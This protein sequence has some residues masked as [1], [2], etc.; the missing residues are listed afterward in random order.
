MNSY[1]TFC[2]LLKILTKKTLYRSSLSFCFLFAN[3]F[4][5]TQKVGIDESLLSVEQQNLWNRLNPNFLKFKITVFIFWMTAF[6]LSKF[7]LVLLECKYLTL[8]IASLCYLV[9]V[10]TGSTLHI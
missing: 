9:Q 5:K 10:L 1:L 7:S 4:Q 8:C 6:V 2:K 3:R